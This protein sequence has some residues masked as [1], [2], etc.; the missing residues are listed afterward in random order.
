MVCYHSAHVVVAGGGRAWR[1]VQ[2]E[3]PRHAPCD[4]QGTLGLVGYLPG[5]QRYSTTAEGGL[6]GNLLMLFNIES[7]TYLL[8]SDKNAVVLE[9][10]IY[11]CMFSLLIL[12]SFASCLAGW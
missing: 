6:P 5:E 4:R 7:T 12:I 9:P 2:P 1:R 8:P 3:G 11:S 10:A